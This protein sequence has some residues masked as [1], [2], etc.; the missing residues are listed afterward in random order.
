MWR[1]KHFQEE[2]GK[3]KRSYVIFWRNRK[4]L[5]LDEDQDTRWS[6]HGAAVSKALTWSYPGGWRVGTLVCWVDSYRLCLWHK[7]SLRT[8]ESRLWSVRDQSHN[9]RRI[10]VG[11]R[12][13]QRQTISLCKEHSNVNDKT[14][15]NL[16]R[17]RIWQM[18]NTACLGCWASGHEFIQQH[19]Q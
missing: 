5:L 9:V 15:L 12:S 14:P 19:D 17:R 16:W 2:L 3:R 6:A 7:S 8:R 11:T 10:S 1:N 13:E 4:E 18:R